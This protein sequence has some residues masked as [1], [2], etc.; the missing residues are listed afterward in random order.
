MWQPLASQTVIV[1]VLHAGTL[2]H[3]YYTV[4][5]KES[6]WGGYV[7][8]LYVYIDLSTAICWLLKRNCKSVSTET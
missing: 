8:R 3:L 7:V 4:K 2:A 1:W 5:S 6:I